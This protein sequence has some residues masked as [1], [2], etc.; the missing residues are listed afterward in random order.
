MAD[1]RLAWD[2]LLLVDGVV[3]TSSSE[4]TDRPDDNISN[5]ARWKIWRSSTA[6]TDQWLKYDL[7]SAKNFQSVLLANYVHHTGGKIKLQAHASD[8]WGS[9]SVNQEITIP[10]SNV[11]KVISYWWSSVQSY[12]WI[13]IL[14][15]NTTSANAY[16]ELGVAFIGSYLVPANS[17][18]PGVNTVR[19]DPSEIIV[20]VEGQETVQQRAKFF[21]VSGQFQVQG[22]S[23]RDNFITMN[24]TIGSSVP[25]FFAVDH[26]DLDQTYYGRF[27]IPLSTV[28]AEGLWS[29]PFGFRESR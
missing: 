21:E 5:R 4:V 27:S 3:L 11:T 12:R 16:T 13:R 7:G 9:P 25:F 6:T 8:S 28:H 18:A 14:F 19:I 10:T 22:D 17:I 26:A 1:A 29:I 15:E 23:D 20:S 24:E 2:N